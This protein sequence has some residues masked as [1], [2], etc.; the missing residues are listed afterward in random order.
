[1]IP[2]SRRWL[3][4]ARSF[5]ARRSAPLPGCPHGNCANCLRYAAAWQEEILSRLDVPQL[6]PRVAV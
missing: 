4:P 5:E 2:A 1:M 6:Y 3:A